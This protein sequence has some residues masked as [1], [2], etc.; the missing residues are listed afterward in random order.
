MER[1]FADHSPTLNICKPYADLN[2]AQGFG[3][4]FASGYDMNL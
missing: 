2:D 3:L 4:I 1:S